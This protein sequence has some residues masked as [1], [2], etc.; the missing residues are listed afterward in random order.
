MVEYHRCLFFIIVLNFES[1]SL[2]TWPPQ[3]VGTTLASLN[4]SHVRYGSSCVY[5][6]RQFQCLYDAVQEYKT[7]FRAIRQLALW[8]VVLLL[9][10]SVSIAVHRHLS[11]SGSG[12][13]WNLITMSTCTKIGITRHSF[14]GSSSDPLSFA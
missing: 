11:W 2:I 3:E 7:A 9:L 12:L 14:E 10:S 6:D 1:R 13:L 8:L 4:A 5:C